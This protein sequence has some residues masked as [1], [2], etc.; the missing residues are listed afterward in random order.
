MKEVGVSLRT[1]F[2]RCHPGIA[3]KDGIRH[4]YNTSRFR[5]LPLFD[6]G[7]SQTNVHLS[8]RRIVPMIPDRDPPL[9]RSVH[10]D[11]AQAIRLRAR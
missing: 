10:E 7:P 4:K 11:S 9:L 6:Q 3:W 8:V 5:K 2:E 1:R